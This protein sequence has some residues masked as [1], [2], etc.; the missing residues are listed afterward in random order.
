MRIAGYSKMECWTVSNQ[1]FLTDTP[2]VFNAVTDQGTPT[3]AR[4]PR[5]PG[6]SG[7]QP[8]AI[9]GRTYTRLAGYLI[10]QFAFTAS[11]LMQPRIASL[12]RSSR[13]CPVDV[14]VS[15]GHLA[16][17]AG[18][19]GYQRISGVDHTHD[20]LLGV[21]PHAPQMRRVGMQWADSR[22]TLNGARRAEQ[23]N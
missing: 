15:H 6:P 18:R 2:G 21:P 19:D 10:A 8:A 14:A 11:W 3:R 13:A 4:S 9:W 12:I 17:V 16:G 23:Q 7:V 20:S 22:M 5:T 1:N